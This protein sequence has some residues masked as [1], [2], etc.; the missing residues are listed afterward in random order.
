MARSATTALTFAAAIAL[1]ATPARAADDASPRGRAVIALDALASSGPERPDVAA[2]ARLSA[3]VRFPRLLLVGSLEVLG[4]LGAPAAQPRLGGLALAGV[5]MG[6]APFE[7]RAFL[8][9]GGVS[10][11]EHRIQVRDYFDGGWSE[12]TWGAIAPRVGVSYRLGG[13]PH[14]GMFAAVLGASVTELF[15][16]RHDDPMR[17]ISTG[18]PVTLVLLSLGAEWSR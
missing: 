9:H 4:P 18:G 17:R 16:P 1:V 6:F 7:D 10:V 2:G 11:G 12:V 5:A 14:G 3:G 8:V 13:R 15:T